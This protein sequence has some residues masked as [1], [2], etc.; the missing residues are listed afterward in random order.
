MHPSK[1]PQ[2]IYC[3]TSRLRF[4][5]SCRFEPIR[6]GGE[7]Y[8]EAFWHSKGFTHQVVA[9]IPDENIIEQ[10][11]RRQKR[12]GRSSSLFSGIPASRTTQRQFTTF[13]A[14]SFTL[15]VLNF[16]L[17]EHSTSSSR[18]CCTFSILP[19]KRKLKGCARAVVQYGPEP[20][21][22]ILD[23]FFNDIV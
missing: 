15:R 16:P 14:P 17:K 8:G 7:S 9:S 21:A 1:L 2:P 20:S 12:H 4:L 3:N 11:T 18:K 22:V 13:C 19:S 23:N 5:Q 10:S 6:I